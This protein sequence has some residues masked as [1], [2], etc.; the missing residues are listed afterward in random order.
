MLY[1][2]IP[3]MWEADA[4]WISVTS[5]HLCLVMLG[6]KSF[7]AESWLPDYWHKQ[8]WSQ[9]Q[10][11]GFTIFEWRLYSGKNR[12]LW[13][14]LFVWFQCHR[15]VIFE[16]LFFIALTLQVG[17]QRSSGLFGCTDSYRMLLLWQTVNSSFGDQK[18]FHILLFYKYNSKFEF[19]Q[20][21]EFWGFASLPPMENATPIFSSSQSPV[22]PFFCVY[23]HMTPDLLKLED[24]SQ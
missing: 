9:I 16:L 17:W 8:S 5:L 1:P 24:R 15:F 7:A 20:L 21:W 4:E 19:W 12:F 3:E 14:D 10:K 22:L 2:Y 23:N 11:L 6:W 13:F 18:V